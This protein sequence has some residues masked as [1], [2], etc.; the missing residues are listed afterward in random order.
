MA[1]G[2]EFVI[3]FCVLSIVSFMSHWKSTTGIYVWLALREWLQCSLLSIVNELFLA[4]LKCF[5]SHMLQW[6]KEGG[7]TVKYNRR[8]FHTIAFDEEHEMCINRD[9]T[10]AVTHIQQMLSYNKLHCFFLAWI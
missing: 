5:P 4:G 8:E 6:L 2:L 3:R 7:F 10:S 9:M 1:E